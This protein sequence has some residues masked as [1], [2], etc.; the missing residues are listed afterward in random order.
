MLAQAM[1][2]YVVAGANRHPAAADWHGE[3]L[4]YGADRN[5]AI[6][7]PQVWIYTFLTVVYGVPTFCHDFLCCSAANSQD[8][9]L[10]HLSLSPPKTI[11][12]VYI[13]RG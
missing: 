2:E 6:W 1:A 4:A 12:P 5:I 3:V 7:K 8:R 11:I 13:S 9:F 10:P